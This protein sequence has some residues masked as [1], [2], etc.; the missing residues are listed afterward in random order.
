ML[1]CHVTMPLNDGLNEHK[2]LH[3][4]VREEQQLQ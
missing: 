4:A 2:K 3:I 1:P